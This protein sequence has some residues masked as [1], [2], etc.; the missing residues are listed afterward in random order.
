V[1]EV[2]VGVERIGYVEVMVTDDEI[3]GCVVEVVEGDW[4]WVDAAFG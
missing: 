4:C 1:V 3:C 2:E